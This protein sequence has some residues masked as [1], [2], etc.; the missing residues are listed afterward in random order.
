VNEADRCL[1][2]EQYEAS[3]GDSTSL[4]ETVLALARE[5]GLDEVLACLEQCVI[6]RR[7]AWF[8]RNAA[9]LPHSG[10]ALMDGYR[11]FYERYLGLSL[12]A[13]GEIVEASPSRIVTRWWN[14]CPTL[15]ACQ[16]L[17][18]DTRRVCRQV[19]HR[20]VQALLERID[21][22][23]QFDR[24]YASLRPAAPYCEE[25]I[26]LESPQPGRWKCPAQK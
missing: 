3:R 22:R 1:I 13:D 19:Y 20:P 18:L 26:E 9:S 14:R 21:P 25:I 8:E 16:K 15:E 6:A 7:M 23:L 10:D 11:A 2:R 4:F 24:N 12:P 17:G 5:F